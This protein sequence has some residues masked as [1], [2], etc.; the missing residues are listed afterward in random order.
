MAGLVRGLAVAG[1]LVAA[2]QSFVMLSG[3]PNF[4][5]PTPIA[6]LQVFMAQGH[7]L[8]PHAGVT[9]LETVL[10]LVFGLLAGVL[11]ATAMAFAL[12]LRRILLPVLVVTQAL[13]VFA[14]AP[15]LVLWFGFGL[16]SKVVMASLIVYF[17]VASTFYDALVRT[18]PT[19]VDLLR[20]SRAT[21]IQTLWLVRIPAALPALGSGLRV[22]ATL[23]PIG[24]IV[25][26]WVGAAAGLGFVMIQAQARVQ[27][28]VVFA[29]LILLMALALLLR[30]AADRLAIR[31]AP[32]AIDTQ[33]PLG[34]RS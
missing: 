28:D 24:A 8:L 32:W 16:T 19:L 23:A 25:G 34:D 4:M 27:T 6:V 7:T 30:A 21:R 26:E 13:P 31:I 10:G 15:L 3:L 5:L 1:G 2:W 18:D 33:Q 22:S 29:A 17:P 20:L 12:P 9:A 11:T 14:I